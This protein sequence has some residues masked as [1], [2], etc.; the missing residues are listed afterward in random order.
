MS[1]EELDLLLNV[2]SE[3]KAEK[4]HVEI[5]TAAGG[6]L[7]RMINCFKGKHH[8]PFVV[9]D[10]MGYFPNQLEVV[11]G[12]L[13]R[14]GVDLGKVEFRQMPSSTALV[15]ARQKG[16]RFSFILIDGR[17]KIRYVMQDLMWGELLEEGGILCL[18]DYL[19]D[20]PG[21]MK[22]VNWF[23]SHKPHYS[24]EGQAGSLLVLK[25]ERLDCTS[26]V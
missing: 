22:S 8:P 17:H 10:P 2:I 25:K 1:K 14:H 19:E 6:T 11:K 24:I 7:W 16:E 12:N 26:E 13:V 3:S 20:H 9:V 4:P 21:V 15:Q 5:G 18:H 23:I